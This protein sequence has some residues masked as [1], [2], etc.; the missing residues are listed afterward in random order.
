M[1]IGIY[2]AKTHFAKLV[3][4]VEKGERVTITRHGKPV[5]V[6]SP[7]HG[8]VR[9]DIDA[10]LGRMQ[11]FREQLAKQGVRVSSREIREWIDEGRP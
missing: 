8:V 3:A 6:L 10:L 11:A 2:E 7:A 9:E 4:R 5:V 1:E